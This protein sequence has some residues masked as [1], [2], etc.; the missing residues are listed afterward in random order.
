MK[1]PE[2]NQK[3]E[4]VKD[5][6]LTSKR[7]KQKYYFTEWDVCRNCDFVQ[8]YEKFKVFNK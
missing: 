5:K 3:M 6:P 7:K 1:C 8:H 2:C 4:R